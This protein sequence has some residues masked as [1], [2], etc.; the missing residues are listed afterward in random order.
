MSGVASSAAPAYNGRP[1]LALIDALGKVSPQARQKAKASAQ[2]FE[3]VFL[4]SMLQQAFAGVKGEG[5]LGSTEGTG[6]WRGMLTDEYAKNMSR[7]GGIGI[8]D[9]VFR[10]LIMQQAAKTD[11]GMT[12]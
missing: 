10:T 5:P 9:D 12:R 1:D 8:A 11:P 6:P 3:Q 4:N 2:D 7:A